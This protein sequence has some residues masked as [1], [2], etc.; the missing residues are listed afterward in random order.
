[1]HIRPELVKI[2]RRACQGFVDTEV[3]N[4]ESDSDVTGGTISECTLPPMSRAQFK[5]RRSR[6]PASACSDVQLPR[7]RATVGLSCLASL[8]G[9]WL[10]GKSGFM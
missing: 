6:R 4:G 10:I 9:S 3:V 5:A 2:E 7:R 1:M 8:M